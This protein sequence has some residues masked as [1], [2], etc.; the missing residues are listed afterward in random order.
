MAGPPDSLL[1]KILE[2]LYQM[3][4]S[5]KL[6]KDYEQHADRMSAKI[7]ET[8]QATLI[9]V[10]EQG[11]DLFGILEGLESKLERII[12]KQEEDAK[13]IEEVK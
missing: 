11:G 3:K 1:S 5:Q 2:I 8:S 6:S 7:M 9:A 10:E 4:D 12:S 13:T